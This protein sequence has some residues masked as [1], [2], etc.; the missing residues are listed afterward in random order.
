MNTVGAGNTFAMSLTETSN[1]R[2]EDHED[3]IYDYRYMNHTQMIKTHPKKV[4]PNVFLGAEEIAALPESMNTRNSGRLRPFF[5]LKDISPGEQ[6][7][8]NYEYHQPCNIVQGQCSCGLTEDEC[9]E[10]KVSVVF[11]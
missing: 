8:W 7:V 2:F 9:Y 10:F 4:Q 3:P 5:A 6:L 1:P 11:R